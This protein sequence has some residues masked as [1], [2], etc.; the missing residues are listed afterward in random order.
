VIAAG[1]VLDPTA[2]HLQTRRRGSTEDD[3]RDAVADDDDASKPKLE[4]EPN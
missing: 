3:H 4:G 1:V 2:H